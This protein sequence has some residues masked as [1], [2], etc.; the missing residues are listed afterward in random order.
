MDV[1]YCDGR[2]V[3]LVPR[4]AQLGFEAPGIF[5]LDADWIGAQGRQR[6]TEAVS[7]P[8][9]PL[10]DPHE[11]WPALLDGLTVERAVHDQL[12]NHERQ[13]FETDWL[14]RAGIRLFAIAMRVMPIR[15]CAAECLQPV[16]NVGDI[17]EPVASDDGL[18]A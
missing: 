10:Y 6:G 18:R 5:R 8:V 13:S 9:Q 2:L 17:G 1:R 11:R 4:A 3:G 16:Q 14:G 15:F 12:D 7:G